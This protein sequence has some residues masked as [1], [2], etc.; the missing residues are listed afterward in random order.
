MKISRKYLV[1]LCLLATVQLFS[2]QNM[3][4]AA[5]SNRFFTLKYEN[6]GISL[7]QNTVDVYPTNYINNNGILGNIY[8]RYVYDKKPDFIDA[9][10]SGETEFILEGKILEKRE[11]TTEQSKPLKLSQSFELRNDELVWFIHLKNTGK[12]SLRIE[13]LAIPVDYNLPYGENPSDIFENSVIKHSFISGNNSYLFFERPTG[14]APYLVMLPLKGTAAEYWEVGPLGDS[15]KR[16][17]NIYLHS[18][19]T[20]NEELRG[21]W[22]QN[23][24]SR[25]LEP[26]Q[27]ISYG[28][29]FRWAGSY[30]GIRQILV[31][32]DMINVEVM[33]GMTVPTDLDVRLALQTHQIIKNIQ[34]EFGGTMTKIDTLER[35]NDGTTVYNIRFSRTGENKLTVNYGDEYKTYL[36][37]FV[38]EPL[39]TLYKKRA[40][41]IVNSQQHKDTTKW[42]D[43][44]F[45]VYDMKNAI[46][47]GPDN[48][49]YFDTSRL[50]Y[51]LTCDDPGLCKAPFLASKNVVFPVAEEINAIEYYIENFVWGGLQRTDKELPYPYGVYGTPDWNYNRNKTEVRE[52]NTKDPNRFKMHVWRSYDYPHIFMLYYHM[53]Q[54]ASFYPELTHYLDADG[55]LIRAKETAKAYFTYPY[56][57]L[58][59]Y[60]TYKWGCYNELLIPELIDVLTAKGFK[61]D[62]TFLR[63]EWEKKVKYF[64][65]DDPYPFRSEYAVDA[66]AFESSYALAKYGVLNQMDP[67]TY[68]WYDKNLKKWYSHPTVSR[69]DANDFMLRQLNANIAQRG[70]LEPAYYF[71]GSDYRGRSDKYTLSY[72]AQMGG[73][74]ILDYA[75]NFAPSDD[76]ALRL[77]Y[78]S[79]LSSFALMNTGTPESNYGFWYPGKENDGASGWAFEPQNYANTWIRKPQGRGPWY[80]DGEI[81]LGYCGALR[82]AATI[83]KRDSVFGI[84]SYGGNLQENDTCYAVIPSDGLRRKFF[85]RLENINFDII[86]SRD[87]LSPDSPVKINKDGS[88]IALV[89]ENRTNDD[90]NSKVKIN[91]LKGLYKVISSSDFNGETDFNLNSDLLIPLQSDTTVVKL[92]RIKE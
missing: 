11:V 92:I 13:D 81:D 43:G 44:L 69:K 61:D 21:T 65:Y 77:G 16:T 2:A 10:H 84:V 88:L 27:E 14:L 70:N 66:T 1:T 36:E 5:F 28:F 57:I 73:W 68:L 8:I 17:Y 75:L 47:R 72:M 32:E 85:C 40:D 6:Y 56:E 20:G 76:A 38:T 87:G 52:A 54:I 18:S 67:D 53:Y 7:L 42:Y 55:Y 83:V 80:Y 91:G 19:F 59:W 46:L 63:N 26:N 34:P 82:T 22:R 35:R 12:T 62:A 86:F 79:Y 45:G 71:L 25:L 24:T 48:A 23:H 30:D 15:K 60:E 64:I 49:D 50:S 39:E 29:K 51:V 9:L 90:H 58:P 33:P 3:K 89:I 41:F 37:F 4:K 31:D 78:Q 74:A